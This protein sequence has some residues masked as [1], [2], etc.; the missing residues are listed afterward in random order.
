ML[1]CEGVHNCKHVCGV[2][3]LIP[4]LATLALFTSFC[5]AARE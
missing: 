4:H 2:F 3:H 1:G 5:R